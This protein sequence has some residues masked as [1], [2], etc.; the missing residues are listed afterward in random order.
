MQWRQNKIGI[1]LIIVICMRLHEMHRPKA[2]VQKKSSTTNHWQREPYTNT[3]T[4]SKFDLFVNYERW[5][6]KLTLYRINCG[7]KNTTNHNY[8]G[9]KNYW[10]PRHHHFCH[11]NT[12]LPELSIQYS[13]VLFSLFVF[14]ISLQNTHTYTCTHNT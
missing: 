6:L 10:F 13:C 11:C 12:V 2:A 8:Y 9:N 4:N 3:N 5:K 1:T 14:L 7:C